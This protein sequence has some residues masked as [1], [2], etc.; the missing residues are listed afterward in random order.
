MTPRPRLR[1]ACTPPCKHF[2][3]RQKHPLFCAMTDILVPERSPLRGCGTSAPP[4]RPT[5]TKNT[6]KIPVPASAPRGFGLG[7]PRYGD[8]DE[9][10]DTVQRSLATVARDA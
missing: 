5:M 9:D 1:E 6:R 4:H 10:T 7:S 2:A 8:R 3:W